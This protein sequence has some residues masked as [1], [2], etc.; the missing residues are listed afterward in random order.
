MTD[1]T[2]QTQGDQSSIA[3]GDEF[4][5][6]TPSGQ[7]DHWTVVEVEVEP[8]YRRGREG[9]CVAIQRPDNPRSWTVVF[10]EDLA[11]GKLELWRDR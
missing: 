10:A 2:P 11:S 3:V 5:G 1:G 7:A 9:L 4:H 8:R 6:R